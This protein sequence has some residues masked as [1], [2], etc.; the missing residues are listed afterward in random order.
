MAKFFISNNGHISY[1][2]LSLLTRADFNHYKINSTLPHSPSTNT[3]S[4]ARTPSTTVLVMSDSQIALL[5]FKNGTKRD[6]TGYP[7]FKSKKYYDTIC[8]SFYVTAKAQGL[9][10]IV[11][12]TFHPKTWQLLCSTAINE[13]QSFMYSI[14]VVTLKPERERNSPRNMKAMLNK[15]L[16]NSIDRIWDF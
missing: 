12:S 10:N 13:Q 9:G 5:N 8:H 6:L 3:P 16:Q 7:I 11:N 15:S 2:N 1:S 4:T 14:L